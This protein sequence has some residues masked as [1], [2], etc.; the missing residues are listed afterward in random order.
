MH[1]SSITAKP[2]RNG[3]LSWPRKAILNG[4]LDTV[5]TVSEKDQQQYWSEN[6]GKSSAYTGNPVIDDS[7]SR[8]GLADPISCNELDAELDSMAE[9]AAGPEG[10]TVQQLKASKRQLLVLLLNVVLQTNVVPRWLVAGRVTFIPKTSEPST[11][12]NYCPIAISPMLLRLFH[13]ILARRLEVL[14]VE[15]AQV[16]YQNVNGCQRNV[17]ILSSFIQ[18][19]QKTKQPLY[20]MFVDVKKAFDSVSCDALMVATRKKGVPKPLLRYL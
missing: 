18:D 17:Y 5:D 9:S 1:R 15:E 3:S 20:A 12:S 19:S 10:M 6:F 7:N 16:A 14:K 13:R 11:H 2:L 8:W 4:T